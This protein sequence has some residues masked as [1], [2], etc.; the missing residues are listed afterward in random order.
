MSVNDVRLVLDGYTVSTPTATFARVGV[1]YVMR[2]KN[3]NRVEFPLNAEPDHM[4]TVGIAF[5]SAAVGEMPAVLFGEI[6]RSDSK[7]RHRAKSA[8]VLDVP[9]ALRHA[10]VEA[11]TGEDEPV[12][13]R[14]SLNAPA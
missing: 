13:S 3:G 5:E 10:R 4:R 6:V 8:R 14:E 9:A 2:D 12:R 1:R 7:G 11:R